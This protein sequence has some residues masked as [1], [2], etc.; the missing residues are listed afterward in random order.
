MRKLIIPLVL[1][2]A[3]PALAQPAPPA[4]PAVAV[5]PAA[6]STCSVTIV[7]APDPVRATIEQWLAKEHCTLALQVRIV[8]TEG[9]LYLLATDEHGRV[10]ERIV[11]DAASAG[12]LIAS[13]A[14]DDGLGGAAPPVA[15]PPPP[16]PAGYSQPAYTGPA[17]IAAPPNYPPPAYAA[18]S[19]PVTAFGPGDFRPTTLRDDDDNGEPTKVIEPP[20]PEKY[21]TLSAG[22]GSNAGGTLRAE[23]DLYSKNGW[24]IGAALGITDSEMNAFDVYST[25]G[26]EYDAHITDYSFALAIGHLWRFGNWHLRGS[27]GLGLVVSTMDV[28]TYDYTNDTYNTG[29]GSMTS[30][31]VETSLMAGHSFGSTKTWGIE[32]G[33]VLSY[34]KQEWYLSDTMSTMYREAGNVM[35]VV[36]LR[37]GL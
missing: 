31:Y 8:P 30:P 33:P 14:A 35:F 12:V 5:A 21:L 18:G 32:A 17:P 23:V 27:V 4:P 37:H 19:G 15:A 28:G 25:N 3:G 13:W 9:G 22:L 11:P 6:P 24:T 16:P 7:R 10:R 1:A 26:G 29:S 20:H 34:T 36:G 2:A